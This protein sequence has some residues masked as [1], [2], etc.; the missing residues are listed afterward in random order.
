MHLFAVSASLN[1][2]I[3]FVKWWSLEHAIE[4]GHVL[5]FYV[6][7]NVLA[8]SMPCSQFIFLNEE[9]MVHVSVMYVFHNCTSFWM[10]N[11]ILPR[12][13]TLGI[14]PISVGSSPLEKYCSLKNMHLYILNNQKLFWTYGSTHSFKDIAL[15]K[16]CPMSI[17]LQYHAKILLFLRHCSSGNA[18]CTP[19]KSMVQLFGILHILV[20]ILSLQKHTALL[21]A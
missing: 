3:F 11:D 1:K 20:W 12:H 5:V 8:H 17:I 7:M 10:H 9:Q 15:L 13:R 18:G 16:G 14:T 19:S 2:C 4:V 21:P 6:K